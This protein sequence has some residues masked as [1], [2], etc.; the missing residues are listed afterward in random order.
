MLVMKKL[1]ALVT[2][3]L[4]MA[5]LAPPPAAAAPPEGACS[6]PG[7]AR[8]AVTEQPWE[9]RM[10]DPRSAVWPHSTGDG[11]RVAVVDSGVS[12]DHPQ[13]SRSVLRGADFYL[14]GDYPGN[15]DCV[16][17]GT[18][19]ASI[20]AADPVEDVGF[21]GLAPDATILPVRVVERGVTERREAQRIDQSVL[22]NGIRY[23]ADQNADVINLSLAGL[24]PNRA[25]RSAIAY[26]QRKDALVVAAVG[27]SRQGESPG[28][29]SYPASYD[30]V[31]GVGAVDMVGQ[32]LSNSR[33]GAQVDLV[34]PGGGVLGAT[35][36]G[37]HQY[38]NGTSFA[39]PFVSATAALVRSAWPEFSAPQVAER[40]V[41]TTTPA[42][43]G[44]GYGA[45]IVN[46]YR[47]VTDRLT[48]AEP[49]ALPDA[50]PAPV[51]PDQV[52]A[53]AWWARAGDTAI[54]TVGSVVAVAALGLVTAVAVAY[55]RRRRWRPRRAAQVPTERVLEG[56]PDEVF[57]LPPPQSER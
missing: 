18:A 33:T 4:A 17:H 56:P 35:R 2:T 43:G 21:A 49:V 27:Q 1:P 6:N 47:A 42:P 48:E 52:R 53:T 28:A 31:L 26:A 38:W 11:V 15:F 50:T 13:L 51:D 34:A 5:V 39:T 36:A 7:P 41:A 32:R 25:V 24:E 8:P 20:I 12:A 23:A 10:L 22:A 37:G 29:P 54:V 16:S 45:G 40:I 14:V 30:G 44:A 9:Q 3:T 57:L 46:P 19:V 55:G